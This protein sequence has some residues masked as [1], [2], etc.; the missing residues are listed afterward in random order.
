MSG[1]G[2]TIWQ[3]V[4]LVAIRMKITALLAHIDR[5]EFNELKKKI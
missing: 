4:K 3:R 1:H 2:L 5:L